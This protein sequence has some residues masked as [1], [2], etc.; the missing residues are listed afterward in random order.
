MNTK[1]IYATQKNLKQVKPNLLYDKLDKH[2]GSNKLNFSN[3]G[4]LRKKNYYKS[5]IKDKPLICLL[6]TSPSPRD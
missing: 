5:S 4:G 1:T 6:Y 2:I 3:S